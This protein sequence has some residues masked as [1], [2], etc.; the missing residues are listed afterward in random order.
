LIIEGFDLSLGLLRAAGVTFLVEIIGMM[1]CRNGLV[2][3]EH[4]TV[5][6]FLDMVCVS[7]IMCDSVKP[8]GLINVKCGVHY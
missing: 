5:I 6:K 8:G 2:K 3:G 1:S 4:V 7:H